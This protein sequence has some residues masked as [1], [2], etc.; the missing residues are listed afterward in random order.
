MNQQ[1]LL[2]T[3]KAIAG[4]ALVKGLRARIV[5]C[6]PSCRCSA[7]Y[8]GRCS[9]RPSNSKIGII[10]AKRKWRCGETCNLVLL[11]LCCQVASYKMW[12]GFFE[13]VSK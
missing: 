4:R 12:G 6:L 2:Q 8:W 3:T 10:G 5:S 9:A 1:Q 7:P 13:D 11:T